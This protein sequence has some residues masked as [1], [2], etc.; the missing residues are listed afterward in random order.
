MRMLRAYLNKGFQSFKPLQSA[1]G[2]TF[3]CADGSGT[4]Q[5]MVLLLP[6]L[7]WEAA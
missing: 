3:K 5:L 4:L 1:I 2:Y 6:G 7:L